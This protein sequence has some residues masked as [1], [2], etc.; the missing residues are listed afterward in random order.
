MLLSLKLKIAV[1]TQIRYST[2]LVI[3]ANDAIY[4]LTAKPDLSSNV[5]PMYLEIKPSGESAS[6]T[7]LTESDMDIFHQALDR[8]FVIR[9]T[10]ATIKTHVTFAV[11]AR[12]AWI[13]IFNRDIEAFGTDNFERKIGYL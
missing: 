8:V 9:C 5:A 7:V 11:T 3:G 6:S 10:N 12:S 4:T 2:C 13:F 1:K